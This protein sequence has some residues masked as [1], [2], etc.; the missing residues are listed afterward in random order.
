MSAYKDL[1]NM[2]RISE[3]RLKI[4]S[5]MSWMFENY[6]LPIEQAEY[7]MDL[8]S[9]ND[10]FFY[11]IQE[12][13]R[14]SFD[15]YIK[16]RI[17]H[18]TNMVNLISGP[19]GQGKSYVSIKIMQM[20]KENRQRF[21]NKSIDFFYAFNPTQLADS[22]K[23]M[24]DGDF[25]QCDEWQNMSGV[26]SRA[27]LEQLENILATM[28]YTEKCINVCTPMDVILIGMTSIIVPYGQKKKFLRI[29][30][31][32]ILME[33]G[34][35]FEETNKI[36]D[37]LYG[38]NWILTKKEFV[39]IKKGI[40]KPDY[41]EMV[42]RCLWYSTSGVGKLKNK[43]FLIGC[44]YLNIGK[45]K[46]Q[47][48]HYEVLKDKNYR[49]LEKKRGSTGAF[50]SERYVYIEEL[51]LKLYRYAKKQGYP[52]EPLKPE[53]QILDLY[54][55]QTGIADGLTLHERERVFKNIVVDFAKKD[56]KGELKEIRKKEKEDIERI[57]KDFDIHKKFTYNEQIILDKYA[58]K[59]KSTRILRDLEIYNK[60]ANKAMLSSKIIDEYPNL[61]TPQAINMIV[62]SIHGYISNELGISYERFRYPY[63]KEMHKSVVWGGGGHLK[64]DF[65]IIKHNGD[66][67][68]ES[69]KCRNFKKKLKMLYSESKVE[70]DSARSYFKDTRKLP[71]VRVHV[72]NRYNE[73]EY[74]NFISPGMITSDMPIT[75]RHKH[76]LLIDEYDKQD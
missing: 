26:N 15:K 66:V 73:K 43:F 56:Y 13:K 5:D 55:A 9:K 67:I 31:A 75:G 32:G 22:L 52:E 74:T 45:I 53:K 64:P 63:L 16:E 54:M 24:N 57:N 71:I 27:V 17:T 72:Y 50:S 3:D 21:Q 35:T 39:L 11:K 30:K 25:C 34:R 12:N 2:L 47:I 28:R 41:R 6:Y 76:N 19:P 60:V 70:I 46:E 4:M 68:F 20:V 10:D 65:I 37:K 23:K 61:K 48:D 40:L 7:Y 14:K 42:T 44:L 8:A 69:T 58:I 62:K 36:L 1:F 33:D 29:Q 59:S 18:N 49:E 51:A 38:E